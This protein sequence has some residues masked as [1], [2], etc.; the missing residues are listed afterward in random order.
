MHDYVPAKPN[1]NTSA[2][3]KTEKER[4]GGA[5][6]GLSAPPPCVAIRAV[7]QGDS[8]RFEPQN[9][10]FQGTIWC[11][12]QTACRHIATFH[13]HFM[14][15]AK[16]APLHSPYHTHAIILIVGYLRLHAHFGR[17]C[18]RRTGICK[19]T[20]LTRRLRPVFNICF[21]V[22]IREMAIVT[23]APDFRP[24]TDRLNQRNL[25]QQKGKLRGNSRCL[26][27]QR[28]LHVRLPERLPALWARERHL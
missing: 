3:T 19:Y 22:L 15:V 21:H 10:L 11:V 25:P 8:G 12:S 24:A 2:H 1:F 17:I 6:Y 26:R 4:R 20:I 27:E 28:E 18:H 9:A 14:G 5:A 23:D 16:S 7:L 13:W